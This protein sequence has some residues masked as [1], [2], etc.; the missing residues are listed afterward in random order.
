L[1]FPIPKN[2]DI[3]RQTAID[4]SWYGERMLYDQNSV[5]YEKWVSFGAYQTNLFKAINPIPSRQWLCAGTINNQKNKN[6]TTW[7][8]G[9]SPSTM[10]SFEWCLS[11]VWEYGHLRIERK[12]FSGRI[13]WEKPD[14]KACNKSQYFAM[15]TTSMHVSMILILSMISVSGKRTSRA[16]DE[17][18]DLKSRNNKNIILSSRR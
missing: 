3:A 6:S 1:V 17:R 14:F 13:K 11:L 16:F 4:W 7:E 8:F 12:C 2:H 10:W 9:D 5:M 18:N 15:N